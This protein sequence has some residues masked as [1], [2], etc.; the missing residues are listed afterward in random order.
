MRNRTALDSRPVP[1]NSNGT[2][3]GLRVTP[4]PA[5]RRRIPLGVLAVLAAVLSALGF[6]AMYLSA[7]SREPV[8]AIA[9]TV[10]AGQV[11]QSED[12][13]VADVSADPAIDPV[14]ADA[15]SEVVGRAAASD[16]VQGSL[17][18]RAHLGTESLLG[19]GESVVGVALRGAQLPTASLQRGD[20]VLV[21]LTGDPAT[22]EGDPPGRR[23]GEARVWAAE[24][25]GD[26][27]GTTVIS[28]VVP[29]EDAPSLM[30]AAA[31]GRL[32]L[33]LVPTR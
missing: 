21:A 13:V 11:I 16:L 1:A 3:A 22:A 12:L 15:R 27:S 6:A 24:L 28:L 10:P 33:A 23:V 4:T 31:A 5:G 14:P 20:R 17:L 9:R 26:S 2:G 18:S 32:S 25:L 8:L 29:E 30:G 7:G 19:E